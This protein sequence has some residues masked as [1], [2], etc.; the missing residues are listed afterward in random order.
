MFRHRTSRRPARHPCTVLDMPIV[1]GP[2]LE[3]ASGAIRIC[4]RVG[5]CSNVHIFICAMDD[6]DAA[7][8]ISGGARSCY[9]VL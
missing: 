3:S 9:A 5:G 1:I 6:A 8:L 2:M 4:S 7:W